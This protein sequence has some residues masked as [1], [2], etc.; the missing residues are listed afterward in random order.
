MPGTVSVLI[1]TFNRSGLIGE[2]MRGVAKQTWRP[3][4][5][6]IVNDASTDDTAAAIEEAK[7]ELEAP[8]FHVV[9]VNLP[10]NRGCGTARAVGLETV[11]GA[12]VAF[13]DDDD[14]WFETKLERQIALLEQTGAGACTC[15]MKQIR[16]E[17]EG[18]YP[19]A[20]KELP[21]GRCAAAWVRGDVLAHINTVV[22]RRE[23][24]PEVGLFPR[25]MRMHDDSVWLAKLAHVA[26]FC[27]LKEVLGVYRFNPAGVSRVYTVDDLAKQDDDMHCYCMLVK[28]DNERRP[29]WDEQAWRDWV[30]SLYPELVKHQLWAG[31]L[32][33]ARKLWK[34]AMQA[35]GADPR[36]ARLRGKLWKG[37][38][39]AL[40]GKRLK[41]PKYPDGRLPGA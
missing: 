33:R 12:Y 17:G 5:L 7:Q 22:F 11:T 37:R 31:R 6:V 38:L 32:G 13:L 20:D 34:F 18:R 26:E 15:Y 29:N 27:A 21:E 1:P 10:E 28:E 4:K 40:F 36:V 14:D 3:I 9:V 25:D 16:P 35:T 41:H 39:L 24:L 19:S 2:A 23:L 8:D 30:K